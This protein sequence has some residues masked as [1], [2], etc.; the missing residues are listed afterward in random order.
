MLLVVAVV[1][2]IFILFIGLMIVGSAPAKKESGKY[3]E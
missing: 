2:L 1:A 3:Y